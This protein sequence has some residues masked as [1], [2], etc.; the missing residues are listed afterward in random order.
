MRSRL[1]PVRALVRTK[2]PSRIA[3]AVAAATGFD[4]NAEY[5]LYMLKRLYP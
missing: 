3:V 2:M 4:M 1:R 5:G